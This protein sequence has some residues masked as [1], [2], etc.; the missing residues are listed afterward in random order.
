MGW[1]FTTDPEFQAKLDWADRFVTDECEPLDLAFPNQ[2]RM[3]PHPALRAVIFPLKDRVRE[4]GLWAAHL[5]PERGGSGYGQLSLALL[6]EVLGRAQWAPV[7][8][9]TQAP[10]SGNAEI[11]AHYGTAHQKAIY[12]EPL[13]SGEIFSCY[14][15]T[16][17]HAGADPKLFTMSARRDGEGW[18]LDGE[19]YF[20]SNASDSAFLIVLAVTNEGADPYRRLSS[21]LVP[22]DTPGLSIIHN[23]DT[24]GTPY[25]YDAPGLRHGNL[26]F[27]AVRLPGD[28]LLGEEGQGFEVAQTR[29]GAGR[30]HHAMRT[31][32]ICKLALEMMCRRALSRQT[33]G[34][35]VA[36]KQLVQEAIA[37]SW[38]E[39]TQFRLMV[40]YTAWLCDQSSTA[41]ARREIAACKVQAAKLMVEVLHRA[42]HVHGALGASNETPLAALWAR[43]P[44]MGIM[45]G[46]TEVHQI[47]VARQ[48]LREYEAYEGVFPPY[49]LPPRIAAARERY[50][51]V[52]DAIEADPERGHTGVT[53]R[54]DDAW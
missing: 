32:A 51:D 5:R 10:D 18:I 12:L 41:D 25:G 45:D 8:F 4:Q 2:E 30:L 23:V 7:I 16:E 11:L 22:S 43:A 34:S 6:N 20:A 28:A 50:R 39:I 47:T 53:V 24:L 17:P 46:P 38:R 27:D 14:S 42:I 26:R 40:L 37:D 36:D 19:K 29:L 9:G 21:F 48:T 52:L 1:D 3:P 31:V 13:L 33:Q 54:A 15:M 49:W 35:R 44:Q